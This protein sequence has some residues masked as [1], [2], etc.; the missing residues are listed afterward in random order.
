MGKIAIV[1]A[2]LVSSAWAADN[3]CTFSKPSGA[4]ACNGSNVCTTS[5]IAADS[6]RAY[7]T[8]TGCTANGYVPTAPDSIVGP[9]GYTVI[10]DDRAFDLGASGNPVYAHPAYIVVDGAG[11][12]YT[13]PPTATITCTGS[14]AAVSVTPFISVWVDMDDARRVSPKRRRQGE[15]G[16]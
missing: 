11:S 14:C 9:D 4:T 13:A 16:G 15:L 5:G 12:G 8:G 10:Y 7:W 6:G 3:V 2:L 1:F